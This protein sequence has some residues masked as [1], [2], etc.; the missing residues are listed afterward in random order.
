MSPTD[1]T[2]F[3]QMKPPHNQGLLSRW[4]DSYAQ[5]HEMA[6]DRV[7]RTIAF[8]LVLAAFEHA[9]SGDP[10][11]VIKGGHAMEIRLGLQAR[12]TKDMDGMVRHAASADEIEDLVRAA[13]ETA[14]HEGAVTFEVRSAYPIGDTGSV[15]FDVRV[16]WR[17]QA[18]AKIKLEISGAEGGAAKS[19]D[20]LP[21][22]N[23]ADQFALG[24][25]ASEVPCLSLRYQMAQKIHAVTDPYEDN[26]RFRDLI[27]L[28]LLDDLEEDDI[29]TVLKS[30]CMEIF[31]LRDRHAWPPRVHVRDGWADGYETMAKDMSFPVTDVA[32]A[33]AAV[34]SMVD[35][36]DA[37]S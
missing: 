19:W 21:S 34:Q 20:S 12:A 26:D 7:R 30:A 16:K 15:R 28:L 33:A 4:I 14:L 36:I 32:V 5:Q 13:L 24:T 37:A 8:E 18:L 17:G 31:A 23:L 29:D 6:A 11:V 27:D 22:F 2:R 3:P 25:G 10:W 9:G 1:P 35:R